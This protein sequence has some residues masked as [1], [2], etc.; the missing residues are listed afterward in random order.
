MNTVKYIYHFNQ[1]SLIYHHHHC[2]FYRNMEGLLMLLLARNIQIIFLMFH[3][4][5][6]TG[7]LIALLN[8]SFRRCLMLQGLKER[9]E[10]LILKTRRI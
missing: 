1:S 7:H 4:I 6:F 5:L 10:Q 3:L 2:S 9:C 8:F